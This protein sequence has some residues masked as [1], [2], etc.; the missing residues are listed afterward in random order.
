M[1]EVKAVPV[2]GSCN[3]V[4]FKRIV[5]NAEGWC[6]SECNITRWE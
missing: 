5:G 3:C 4:M 1:K 6:C 2:C